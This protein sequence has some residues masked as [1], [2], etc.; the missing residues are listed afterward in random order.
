MGIKSFLKNIGKNTIYYPGC[1]TKHVLSS[2]FENY[3][4]MLEKIG[5]DFI[6]LPDILCC[7][8]PALNAGYEHEARKL[9]RK[10]LEIF[11]KYNTKKII[12]NCPACFKVLNKEYKEM[13]PDWD[14]EV[15]HLITI[16]L[17]YLKERNINLEKREKIAYHDPCH[18]GRH[19]SIY[20]EPREILRRLGYEVAEMKHNKE[21][22]LCC[23]GG[24]G[25]KTN[26]PELAAKIARARIKEA[27]E[28]G[29]KKII[30]PCPLCFAH[31]YEN[32]GIEVIEFSHAVAESLGIPAEKTKLNKNELK[33]ACS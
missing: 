18:L 16:V 20:D 10:N 13:L 6:I 30:T 33:E 28:A 27:K 23:G 26:N 17:N 8:S 25:L 9:A 5:I 14:M 22:S 32:A 1:L 24:A 4:K 29:V 11:R 31:M 19:L 7:G 15:E 3:R 21:N 12:T 2:E